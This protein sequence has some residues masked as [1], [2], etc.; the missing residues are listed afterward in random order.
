MNFNFLIGFVACV[1]ISVI[2]KTVFQ[3]LQTMFCSFST[4]QSNFRNFL[5]LKTLQMLRLF[6]SM[7]TNHLE[8]HIQLNYHLSMYDKIS[9]LLATLNYLKPL[10]NLGRALMLALDTEFRTS[11]KAFCALNTKLSIASGFQEK[12]IETPK[13]SV[14]GHFWKI[15]E[16]NT[17]VLEPSL[18]SEI[19]NW[20]LLLK[21]SLKPNW[22]HAPLSRGWVYVRGAR[23]KETHYGGP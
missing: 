15:V 2:S 8:E 4:F 16:L 6:S 14:F 20:F 17:D 7:W 3:Y 5:V 13:N 9:Q 11:K 10:M 1:T 19:D 21:M 18:L 23:E 22:L 12:E